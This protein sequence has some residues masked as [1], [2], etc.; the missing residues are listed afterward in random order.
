MLTI[1]LWRKGKL[2]KVLAG[3][4]VV[5]LLIFLSS[6]PPAVKQPG[7]A[8]VVAGMDVGAGVGEDAA[9]LVERLSLSVAVILTR[10]EAAPVLTATPV[11]TA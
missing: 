2:G 10:T 11:E 8:N 4:W 3:V 5:L 1:W 6:G 7:P 9:D